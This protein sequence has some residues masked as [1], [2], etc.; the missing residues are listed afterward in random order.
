M[1]ITEEQK[2]A[3]IRY[4]RKHYADPSGDDIEI[5]DN[6]SVSIADDP[7]LTR[8]IWVSAWVWVPIDEEKEAQP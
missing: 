3:A 5:D 8:G 2:A 6:P 4:A 7:T 1:S